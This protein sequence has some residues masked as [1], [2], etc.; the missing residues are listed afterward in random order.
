M[1]SLILKHIVV[2]WLKLEVNYCTAGFD[3][4]IHHKRW[5]MKV[6]CF[7]LKLEMYIIGCR[8]KWFM[9]RRSLRNQN[10]WVWSPNG[11][12][13]TRC[14]GITYRM[15]TTILYF[16]ASNVCPTEIRMTLNCGFLTY[17][18]LVNPSLWLRTNISR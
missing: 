8:L 9:V 18:L 1:S 14:W 3:T 2:M 15:T 6:Q 7:K 13:K 11:I 10:F 5:K 12:P 16:L 17:I 4:I